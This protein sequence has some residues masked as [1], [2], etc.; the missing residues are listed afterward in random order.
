MPKKSAG[1][2][3][4]V[5]LLLIPA[6]ADKSKKA[7]ELIYQDVQIIRQQI[8]QLE[9]KIKRNTEDIESIKNQLKE[10]MTQLRLLQTDQAA[11]KEGIKVIPTHYQVILN[12]LE[13][14]SLQITR[15]SEELMVLKEAALPALPSKEEQAEEKPAPS[16]SEETKQEQK[17]EQ[18][19]EKPETSPV[20][21]SPQEVY[22]MALSD[23]RNG[24]FQLAVDG[25]KM[26]INQFPGSPFT[27]NA[28]YWIG[29][30]FFSQGKFEEAIEE[31][32][33]LILNYPNGDKIPGAYLKKGICFIELGKREEAL[34]VFKLL[35]NKYPLSEETK[36][37]QQKMRALLSRNERHQQP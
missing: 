25:F 23:Y 31:F 10:L 7:Y 12:K 16:K 36:I 21:L 11:L 34:T 8:I 4:V 1:V 20:S 9:K 13:E 5:L 27:D 26:Y 18:E 14:M 17:S 32:N 22:N 30:C 35:I 15:V 24:N 28:Q 6:R 19:E 2:F 29:E 33:N 37:A 3:L